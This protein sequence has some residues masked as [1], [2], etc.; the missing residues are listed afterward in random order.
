[1]G[2]AP[3]LPADTSQPRTLLAE[4]IVDPRHPLTARVMVNRIWA[5]LVGQGIVT[6]C[7]DLGRNGDRPSHPELLDYL[8]HEFVQGGWHTKAIVRQIVLSRFF[9]Q[10]TSNPQALL[11][12][13]KDPTNRL[14]WRFNRRRLAAE[15]LRDA[16]L[17]VSGRLN[18]AMGG[19]AVMVEVERDLVELLY[20]PAQWQVTERAEEHDRRS[21]YLLAKRNLRLPFMEVFDQ[22]DLQTSCPRR[23]SSTH[24]L[25]ALELL[26]GRLS[27]QLAGAFATRL[28]SEVGEEATAL[29]DRAFWLALGR[30][31]TDA[32]RTSAER[33][34]ETRPLEELALAMF[35]LNAFMY[36]D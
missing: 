13:A 34:A 15:E 36:V 25:Q 29:V 12:L 4:Q 28:K 33:F 32:E 17:M 22:P 27:N 19:P 14:L 10:A 3:E 5:F 2:D 30:A 20:D 8:A 24:A 16:M 21:I 23:E 7:N 9:C 26:N 6:T 35:N 11:A 18:P 31:P 1:L